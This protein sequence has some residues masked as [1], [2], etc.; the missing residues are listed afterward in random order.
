ML[1]L[2]YSPNIAGISLSEVDDVEVEVP[3]VLLPTQ[4][5]GV[6]HG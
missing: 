1:T 6:P 3:H 5:H 4:T 2:R